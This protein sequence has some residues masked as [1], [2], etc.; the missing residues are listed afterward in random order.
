[1]AP[2][3]MSPMNGRK[4]SRPLSHTA[5]S[6]TTTATSPRPRRSSLGCGW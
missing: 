3:E 6:A 4:S 1:M 2:S 5:A